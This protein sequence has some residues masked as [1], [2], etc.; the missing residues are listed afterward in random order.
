MVGPYELYMELVH[1]YKWPKVNE[2]AWGYFT[3]LIGVIYFT[4]FI[5]GFWAHL[6]KPPKPEITPMRYRVK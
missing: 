5:T 3:L 1:T 4:P 2:F 6:I